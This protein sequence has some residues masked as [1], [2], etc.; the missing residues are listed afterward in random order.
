[1]DA[2]DLDEQEHR[3]A[4]GGLAILNHLSRP[5]HSY[6]P[7][8]LALATS[9]GR[10]LR[11]LDVACGGGDVPLALARLAKRAGVD[12]ELV[13]ADKSATALELARRAAGEVPVK[14]VLCDAFDARLPEADIVTSSLFLHHLDAA[15]VVHLLGHI[16]QRA[17]HLLLIS[18][19]SRSPIG[20]AVAWAMC[21]LV[22]R[23]P[24]VWHDGPASVRAAWTTDELRGF[25][26]QAGL[27]D[28]AV[29]PVWPWRMLLSWRRA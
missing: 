24:V 12:I 2:P 7:H 13:L 11:L 18:D 16:A 5:A 14:T 25:A 8:V 17:R 10:K 4:L 20:L 1:M 23:S 28:A 9:A 3:S 26:R 21:R 19:L 29:R 22:S 6:L 27:A 15:N